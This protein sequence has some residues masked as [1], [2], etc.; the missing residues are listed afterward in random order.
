MLADLDVPDWLLVLNA[1]FDMAMWSLSRF[2]LG[3]EP[4]SIGFGSLK[5][6]GLDANDLVRSANEFRV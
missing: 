4:I 6:I 3:T 5:L 1:F 2:K